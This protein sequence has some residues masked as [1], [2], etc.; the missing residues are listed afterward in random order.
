VAGTRLSSVLGMF[1]RLPFIYNMAVT[2]HARFD[3]RCWSTV[4][5]FFRLLA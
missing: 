2:G 5:D 1:R 4:A 3:L